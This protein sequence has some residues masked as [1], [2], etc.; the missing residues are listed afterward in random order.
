MI[1]SHSTLLLSLLLSLYLLVTTLTMARVI[2]SFLELGLSP[3]FDTQVEPTVKPPSLGSYLDFKIAKSLIG[4]FFLAFLGHFSWHWNPP[5][6]HWPWLFPL[7]MLS[8]WT[9]VNLLTQGNLTHMEALRRAGVTQG[10][11]LSSGFSCPYPY[12]HFVHWVA[13]S[14]SP[15]DLHPPLQISKNAREHCCLQWHLSKFQFLYKGCTHMMRV[16]VSPEASTI[17]A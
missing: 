10:Y 4:W 2:S 3:S 8:L 15:H 1:T 6:I 9:P 13:S 17:W 11:A 12:L 14:Q 7:A 5:H 16:W